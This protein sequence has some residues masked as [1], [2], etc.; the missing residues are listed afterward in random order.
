MKFIVIITILAV[1][2]LSF[3]G[4][5][6]VASRSEADPKTAP[7]QVLP[8][9]VVD[10]YEI[11]PE[12]ELQSVCRD[13]NDCKYALLVTRDQWEIELRT[14][15]IKDG[16]ESVDRQW[17]RVSEVEAEALN[18]GQQIDKDEIYEMRTF[19]KANGEVEAQGQAA[20]DLMRKL[21]KE[22]NAFGRLTH[23]QVNPDGQTM[24]IIGKSEELPA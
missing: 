17:V 21:V 12:L 9:A 13:L 19:G 24:H 16:R 8:T 7:D 10:I 2:A 23:W 5:H 3:W 1:C 11:A 18:V 15:S 14:A 22:E 4:G 6:A 20:L